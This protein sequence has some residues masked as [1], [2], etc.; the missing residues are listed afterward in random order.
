[1]FTIAEIRSW[2][3]QRIREEIADQRRWVAEGGAEDY[4]MS[5]E[6]LHRLYT[7]LDERND[8]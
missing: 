4:S 8:G 1:M 3:T 2:S 7:V 6:Y 5:N